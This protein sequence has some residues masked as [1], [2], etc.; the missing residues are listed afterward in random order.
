MHLLK[1]FDW[2]RVVDWLFLLKLRLYPRNRVV[3]RQFKVALGLWLGLGLGLGLLR[4]GL[5]DFEF[6]TF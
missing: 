2:D 3:Y 6:P 5:V 4:L 1:S